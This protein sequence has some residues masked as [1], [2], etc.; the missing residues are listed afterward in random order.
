M[1]LR[2]K[3]LKSLDFIVRIKSTT[4]TGWGRG[5]KNSKR[6]YRT[7]QNIRIINAF[8][9]SLLSESFPLLGVSP[10]HLPRDAL[11]HCAGLWTCCRG[12]LDSN[13][14]LVCSCLQCPQLLE[15]MCFLLWELSMTFYI[16]HGPRVWLVDHMD[17]ICSL[18][19]WWEGF[20]SSPLATLPLGFNCGF[21]STSARCG[22]GAAAWVSGVLAAPDT[23]G[24]WQLGQQEIIVL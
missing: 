7:S 22:G 2:E 3:K 20:G 1:W 23:Q 4:T 18:Y 5:E 13:L 8:L 19:N 16:F 12:S 6:I 21:I 10:P 11:Q 17:L 9:E 24:S 15:V 14:V